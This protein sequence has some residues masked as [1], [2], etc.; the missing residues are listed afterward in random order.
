MAIIM[1][2][3]DENGQWSVTDAGQAFCCN[4]VRVRMRKR[5]REEVRLGALKRCSG[6]DTR[7]LA[8]LYQG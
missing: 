7:D 5:T 1:S 3:N 4:F 8:R 6:D 2:D